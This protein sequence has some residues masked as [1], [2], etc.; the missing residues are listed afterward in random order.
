MKPLVASRR[1]CGQNGIVL[2]VV[3]VLALAVAGWPTQGADVLQ[4][5]IRGGFSVAEADA[6]TGARKYALWG[7]S[8]TPLTADRW[9]IRSPRLE[10]YGEGDTTNLVFRPST[11]LFDRKTQQITS[12]EPLQIWSG[13]G[14][15][16]MQGEG[17]SLD[18]EAR[19]LW[20]SN[21]VEAVMN[22]RLFERQGAGTIGDVRPGVAGAGPEVIRIQSHRLE[23]G[24]ERAK[25]LD[26]VRAEDGEARLE[27]QELSVDLTPGS[28][29][30]RGL[31]A[32]GGVRFESGELVVESSE[33]DYDPA[34]GRLELGG[35]PRW[36]YRG[37]PGQAQRVVLDR[38]RRA[39]SAT[40]GV[41]M[42]LPGESFVMP[43]FAGSAF[44]PSR[45]GQTPSGPVLIIA[46]VLEVEPRG[47]GVDGQAIVLRG[48]VS[49]EQ[50][51]NRVR[52]NELRLWTEGRDM[53]QTAAA[54][55]VLIERGAEWLRCERADYDA[56][57]A[58]AAFGGG[59]EWHTPA[60]S[61]SADRVLLDL[62][63]NR[64]RAEGAV[65]MRFLQS[66][67]SWVEWMRPEAGAGTSDSALPG[68]SGTGDG[69]PTEVECDDFEYRGGSGE[70]DIQ[71]ALYEGNVLVKQGDRMHLSCSTLRAE[72][73]PETNQVRSVVA[74]GG[75]E[76]RA[77]EESGYRLARGDRAVYSAEEEQVVLSGREGVDFFVIAPSGVSRAV[78]RQAIYRRESDTLILAGDP[79][80]TTPEGELVGRE[81]KL[82]RR[83]GVMSAT[84]PWQIRLPLG[85][86]ELPRMPGP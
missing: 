32:A 60:R 57:A 1:P 66:G 28:P 44:G 15:L 18:L 84:G 71:T 33:A 6:D 86:L 82:D 79:A 54:G 52:C 8:A 19:R 7:E 11:C 42:E 75:V 37:R 36:Q 27:C 78:G 49:I 30:V 69:E 14:Y 64:H 59:V 77:N 13:D 4:G 2:A 23:Y 53:A 22:K 76:I 12:S 20:V 51:E 50:G 24:N 56:A 47:D 55:N 80:I 58:A 46:E 5:P 38:D 63:E 35:E 73:G 48:E 72:L 31:R 45:Q 9:E 21:R 3:G 41:R 39:M 10:L 81:V 65:R 25:F 16:Q 61:G 83:R 29:D 67:E 70:G 34:A 43:E 74:D 85:G 26:R 17:F 40:G 68:A 62:A